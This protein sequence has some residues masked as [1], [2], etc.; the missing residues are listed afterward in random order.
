[1]A[2]IGDFPIFNFVTFAL[3]TDTLKGRKR[4]IRT[5]KKK[6]LKGYEI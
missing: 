2:I 5:F 1:M 3:K 4:T 6:F